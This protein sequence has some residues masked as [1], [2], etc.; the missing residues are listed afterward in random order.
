MR[1]VATLISDR[2]EALKILREAPNNSVILLPETVSFLST[3]LKPYSI[4][5]NLF[6]IY[7]SD[8]KVFV[9]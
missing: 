6:I 4:E 1:L 3:T 9:H 5:K 7:Q 2:A 8:T